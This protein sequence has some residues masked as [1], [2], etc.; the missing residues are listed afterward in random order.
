INID[1]HEFAQLKVL[2]DEIFGEENFIS[3]FPWHNRTSVQNDTDISIN[4]EYL[5]AYAKNRR[6]VNRRLKPSNQAEWHSL[7]DFV[8]QPKKTDPAKYSNPDGDPRGLWKADPFDAPGVREN[9]TYEI[10]N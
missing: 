9:L 5:L 1:D 10:Q 6:Q 4:H 3:C 7:R 8:F 2:C